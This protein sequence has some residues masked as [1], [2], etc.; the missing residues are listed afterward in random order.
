M[1]ILTSV[2][3]LD[4]VDGSGDLPPL[5]KPQKREF[6]FNLSNV[7]KTQNENSSV[8]WNFG[9][10]GSTGNEV[11]S[12]SITKSNVEYTYTNPGTYHVHSIATVEGVLFHLQE[13]LVIEGDVDMRT[14]APIHWNAIVDLIEGLPLTPTQ[15]NAT[16]DVGGSF[17]Y[18][19][20]AG[21]IL[22]EGT[23]TLT[24]IFTPTDDTLYLPNTI[25]QTITI[26]MAPAILSF[27]IPETIIAPTTITPTATTEGVVDGFN[28]SED[29]TTPDTN[30]TWITEPL[31]YEVK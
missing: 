4:E 7:N 19:P 21:T 5:I 18:S 23:H 29:P 13:T 15:L 8:F 3:K 31:T 26:A 27:S 30:A 14:P 25:T 22:A 17:V 1:S 24:A 16:S 12:P 6:S 2:Y 20:G 11:I 28:I 9:D 10:H